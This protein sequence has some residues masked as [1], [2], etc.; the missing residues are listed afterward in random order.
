M[1][2]KHYKI[3]YMERCHFSKEMQSIP[4]RREIVKMLRIIV[5]AWIGMWLFSHQVMSNS[6]QIGLMELYFLLSN[7]MIFQ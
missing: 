4:F 5:F 6:L 2:L 7:F 1:N 3:V